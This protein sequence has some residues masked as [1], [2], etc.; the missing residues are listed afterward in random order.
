M[1]DR[2]A[3]ERVRDEINRAIAPPMDPQSALDLMGEIGA[4]VEGIIE[5]IRNDMQDD[6]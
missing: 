4:D 2:E 5:G 3:L 1:V 6:G